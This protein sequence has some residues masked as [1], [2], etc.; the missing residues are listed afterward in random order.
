MPSRPPQSPRNSTAA[1]SLRS[2]MARIERRLESLEVLYKISNIINRTVEREKVLKAILR[3]V[4]RITRASSG[5][6]AMLD[7]KRG[8]LDI[9]T[10][11]NIPEDRWKKLK[12]QVGIGITGWV[13]FTKKPARVNDVRRD[14]HYV[15]L[16]P[17]VRAELAVP[18]LLNGEVIGVINVDSHQLNAFTQDDE[19]L[20]IA[21]AEQSTRVIE[22]ARLYDRQRKHAEQ[23]EALIGL[24]QELVRPIALGQLF[25]LIARE[26][27]RLLEADACTLFELTDD[28]TELVIRAQSTSAVPPIVVNELR[29]RDTT[30]AP[31][32]RRH[33]AMVVED[34][35]RVRVALDPRLA[36]IDEVGAMMAVPL[37][38]EEGSDAA[39]AVF[40]SAERELPRSQV[41]LLQ[42]LANQAAVAIE[43][44]R[45]RDRIQAMEENLHQVEKF[46]LL[47]TLA[48]EIAHE[49]RNPVTIINLL[50]ESIGEETKAN[51]QATNDLGI[52]RTKLDRIERIV[53]QTLGISRNREPVLEPLSINV[54]VADVLLFMNYKFSKAGVDVRHVVDETL[55][56]VSIDRG[57]MQQ[58]LLNL[59]VN[60]VEAMPEGGRVT[61][62]TKSLTDARLG[63]CVAVAVQDTGVGI[64]AEHQPSLFDPFF[65]TRPNGTGLGLFIS[66]RLAV[67]HG[68]E[69]RVKSKL[70]KGSTFTLLLPVRTP[71]AGA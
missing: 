48:A 55:P 4:V 7:H 3:E 62:T 23:M 63:P 15:P 24:A 34:A 19:D 45:R 2:S 57:Q 29:L 36:G 65:T 12:L 28:R 18:M 46:S 44:A 1:N 39:L 61:V 70:G 10:A 67:A 33:R 66:N 37:I 64:A 47:G 56:R 49:I 40:Y 20:L 52:V 60:A 42:L 21:A 54:V 69:L 14:S 43:N 6:I 11:I 5:S 59:M 41:G 58:V 13:A 26:G 9:E 16:K 8:L 51:A 71:E 25:E 35:T 30:I 53:D 22:T 32:I 50:L 38:Y 68:G 17:D 31:T 27:Q